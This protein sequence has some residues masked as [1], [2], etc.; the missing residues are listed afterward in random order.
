MRVTKHAQ[1]RGRERMGVNMGKLSQEMHRRQLVLPDGK[2]H[3]PG[4]GWLI[5]QD[6]ALITVLGDQMVT[7]KG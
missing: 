4:W 6:G 3:I 7:T 1:A 2:H 5:V